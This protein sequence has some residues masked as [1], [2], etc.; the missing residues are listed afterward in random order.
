MEKF[1]KF[2]DEVMHK[3]LIARCDVIEF[4]MKFSEDP[5]LGSLFYLLLDQMM[6]FYEKFQSPFYGK[7]Q[8]YHDFIFESGIL[9]NYE[10]SDCKGQ[11][12]LTEA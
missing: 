6:P 5:D 2:N 7:L 9:T 10:V 8:T 11:S 4:A 1:V 12:S 3:A